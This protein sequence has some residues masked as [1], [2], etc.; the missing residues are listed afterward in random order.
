[1][2]EKRNSKVTTRTT[3]TLNSYPKYSIHFFD[4][5]PL[6]FALWMGIYGFGYFMKDEIV[7]RFDENQNENKI[8][9][10]FKENSSNTHMVMWWS[11]ELKQMLL[12][13]TFNFTEHC[14]WAN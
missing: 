7:E 11:C 13:F 2:T 14:I 3:Q 9:G 1:M 6:L 8:S 5:L 4:G 12:M 10:H